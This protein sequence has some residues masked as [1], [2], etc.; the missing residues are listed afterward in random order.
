MKAEEGTA[1]V[2]RG[3]CESEDVGV[4]GR[5]KSNGDENARSSGDDGSQ[6]SWSDDVSGDDGGVGAGACGGDGV[7]V[8][9][10]V[11]VDCVCARRRSESGMR[12]RN[13]EQCIVHW[14]VLYCRISLRLEKIQGCDPKVAEGGMTASRGQCFCVSV[15][16][17]SWWPGEKCAD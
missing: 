5:E 17:E 14:N 3:S 12:V 6:W 9:S 7:N 1:P 4:E 10:D 8:M 2:E 15:S 11:S 13:L 16:Q